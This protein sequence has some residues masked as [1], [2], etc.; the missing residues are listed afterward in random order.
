MGLAGIGP[1]LFMQ[2]LP[3]GAF[4]TKCGAVPMP[5]T[6]PCETGVS[7]APVS[8]SANLMLEDPA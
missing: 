7:A 3:S 6:C 4:A 8:N 2:R 1:P 5:S